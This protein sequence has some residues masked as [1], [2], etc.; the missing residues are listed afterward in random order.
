MGFK[1]DREF[2][3]NITVGAVGTRQVASLLNAGGFRII[4]L[5]RTAISN[6]LWATKIKRLRVPDLLCLRSGT[7]IESRAK[8]TLKV[9]MSHA[10]NNPDRAWD[11]GLRDDDLVAF[12]KCYEERGRWR[13]ADT[14]S[15]FRVS[16]MRATEE[17]AGLSQMK[18]A[19]E[20]NEIQLTWP[21]TIPSQAGRVE[22]IEEDRVKTLL[23]SNRR[24]SYKLVSKKK[25]GA[26]YRLTPYV[27]VGDEFSGEEQVI[28]SVMTELIQPVLADCDQYDFISDLGA[29]DHETVYAAAK[30]LG[31]L[32]ELKEQS[33]QPLR[34]VM[35]EGA[36]PLLSL[37]AA[38]ALA[39]LVVSDG[40]KGIAA[41]AVNTHDDIKM[42]AALILGELPGRKPLRAK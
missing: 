23:A 10:V 37:E 26:E 17:A 2:L 6:K 19:A 34:T 16:D 22:A 36:N 38:G 41:A 3:R 9:T 4:E 29:E 24:Q 28:A 8:G 31:F 14:V 21:S 39:R 25:G 13:P 5:E 30:A 32:P 20:G 1:T 40:W 27:G 18:S 7:R 11:K 42:E 12:I 33:T 35:N 15:L